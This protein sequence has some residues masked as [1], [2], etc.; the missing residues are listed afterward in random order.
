MN[1]HTEK[2]DRAPGIGARRAD[3]GAAGFTLTELL[4]TTLILAMMIGLATSMLVP[5]QNA[6]RLA[7]ET[8]RAN[9][10][11]R[12]A[13]SI[14]RT[15]LAAIDKDGFL[16]VLCAEP[17]GDAD[18]APDK[19]HL[20]FTTAGNYLSQCVRPTP[21]QP[22]V[23]QMEANSAR[24]DFSTAV[25]V[26]DA[27][28]PTF[29]QDDIIQESLYGREILLNPDD[30]TAFKDGEDHERLAVSYYRWDPGK[31][32]G[33]LVDGTLGI[34]T[35]EESFN[36]NKHPD[37]AAFYLF[38]AMCSA[39]GPD[40]NLPVQSLTDL[41]GLWSYVISDVRDFKVQWTDGT[42]TDGKLQWYTKAHPKDTNWA[43]KDANVVDALSKA[44]GFCEFD[45]NGFSAQSRKAHYCVI[46]SYWNRYAWPKALRIQFKV[47]KRQEP[48]EVIVDLPS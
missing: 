2:H 39:A 40:F 35:R 11:A 31:P 23:K 29:T 46:W 25:K 41:K 42:I 20:I 36:F 6:I 45:S 12:A 10:N 14:F 24:V 3:K 21:Q 7:Q 18:D 9:A 47:G 4:V 28:T 5:A 17:E 34:W 16:I 32:I 8:V 26:D 13:A 33:V 43:D 38:P 27:G 30:P 37:G 22:T 1:R 19:H 44:R 15:R 48:Y